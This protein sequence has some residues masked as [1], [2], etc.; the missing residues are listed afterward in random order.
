MAESPVHKERVVA[1]V[2]WMR[3]EGVVVTH[4]SGGLPLPIHTRSSAMSQRP[5][6]PRGASLV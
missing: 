1:M 3:Q 2:E 5:L 6:E 4:A